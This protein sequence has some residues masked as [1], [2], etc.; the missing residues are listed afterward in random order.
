MRTNTNRK[1][2]PAWV[3]AAALGAGTV[4]AFYAAPAMAADDPQ[5]VREDRV[6]PAVLATARQ[7]IL[8]SRD[9]VYRKNGNE[10]VINFTTPTGI[11]LQT[12]VHEDGRL[13]R[14]AELAPNQPDGAPKRDERERLLLQWQQRVQQGNAGV[15][16][17]GQPP[18]I[19][20]PPVGQPPLNVPPLPG[21]PPVPVAIVPTQLQPN[22]VPPAVLR[23]FDQ[24]T[25]GGRD[26]AYYQL[27]ADQFLRYEANWT[28]ADGSRR[29]VQVTQDGTLSAGPSVLQETVTDAQL[30]ADRPDAGQP[31]RT[32]QITAADVTPLAQQTVAKY[33]P[34][35][36]ADVRYRRDFFANGTS[37]FGV[38]WILPQNG[39]RYWMA[40]GENGVVLTAPRLSSFQPA[41]ADTEGVRSTS[42][43]REALPANVRAAMDQVTRNDRDARYFQQ[44][45]EGRTFYGVEWNDAAN[46]RMWLRTDAA[47]TVV[48]GPVLA[49][50]GR[51]AAPAYEPRPA[52]DRIPAGRND[53][54]G[55]DRPPLND[56]PGN[57]RPAARLPR[58]V[59]DMVQQRTQG[60]RDVVTT[61]ANEGG[62]VIY[63]TTWV[64]A[65]GRQHQLRLDERGR[66]VVN[67]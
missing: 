33:V 45:R 65:D 4:P 48:A 18:V 47:G 31:S 37:S 59:E 62:R 55:N 40:I 43:R 8:D 29:E 66:D 67:K 32:V 35:E 39:K 38:H 41:P 57:D 15:V 56:R 51:K 5:T 2:I 25:V 7:Q 50:T 10:Y 1:T 64:G 61:P 46:K 23:S 3:L 54:P 52:G 63:V 12:R 27:R 9:V 13:D 34:R 49:E 6:P 28:A 22:Q 17:P 14:P 24:Y 26:V 19:V 53:R 20:Q 42:I 30:E 60:G 36:A 44:L 11:R 58:A 16:P 21:Q